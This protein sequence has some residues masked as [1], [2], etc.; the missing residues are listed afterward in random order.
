MVLMFCNVLLMMGS[1]GGCRLRAQQPLTGNECVHLPVRVISTPS[2]RFRFAAAVHSKGIYHILS[3]LML[4][5]GR[6]C[7]GTISVSLGQSEF[8]ISVTKRNANTEEHIGNSA[9]TM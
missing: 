4:E 6:D 7:A 3:G 1:S 5:Q 2:I 8:R 9:L